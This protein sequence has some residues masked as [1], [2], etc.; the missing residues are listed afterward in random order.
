MLR[1]DP[2]SPCVPVGWRVA[3]FGRLGRRWR[4]VRLDIGTPWAQEDMLHSVG[5]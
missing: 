5:R 4:R 3:L 1:M 2:D